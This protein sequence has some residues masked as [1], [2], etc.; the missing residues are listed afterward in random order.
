MNTAPQIQELLDQFGG[1]ML[2]FLPVL[3][4]SVEFIKHKLG[5]TGRVVEWITVG[6]FVVFGA[7]VVASYYFPEQGAGIAAVT[8]FLMMC[9]LAPSGFYKFI[10]D[11]QPAGGSSGLR[12][13]VKKVAP[14]PPKKSDQAADHGALQWVVQDASEDAEE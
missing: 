6:I 1:M 14:I 10:N 9:A 3:F 2:I 4:G 5:F 8:L 13:T 11:R 12:L 7:L